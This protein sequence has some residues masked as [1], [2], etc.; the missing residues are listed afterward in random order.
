MKLAELPDDPLDRQLIEATANWER[1][2]WRGHVLWQNLI[3]LNVI[4]EYVLGRCPEVVIETGTWRGGSAIF[5]A[6]MMRL[7]GRESDV[8]TVDH[9]PRATPAY[10]GV[11][12]MSGRSS[13]DPA[14]LE[15]VAAR[16]RGRRAFVVLDSN[17]SGPH[18][19]AE[20]EVY[21]RFVQPGDHILVQDGNVYR[22]L[23]WRFEETP[24]WAIERFVT[25]SPHFEIDGARS[26]FATTAHPCGWLRRL[27]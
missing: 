18:V 1:A 14:V 27:S 11:T 25:A 23:N 9:N 4:S 20:L 17:H 3:D 15:D 7:A 10:T 2:R 5:F 6:D 24:L 8:I 26:P 12:Y 19:L 13:I 16:V 22:S 21:Q